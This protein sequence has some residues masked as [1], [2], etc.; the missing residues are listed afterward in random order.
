MVEEEPIGV[1]VVTPTEPGPFDDEHVAF[2]RRLP[3]SSHRDSNARLIEAVDRQR[4][5]LPRSSH[6][7]LPT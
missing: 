4:T 6:L 2:C 3:T 5:E 1:V 7:R